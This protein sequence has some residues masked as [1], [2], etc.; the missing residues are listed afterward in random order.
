MSAS[1][2]VVNGEMPVCQVMSSHVTGQ[3][4]RESATAVAPG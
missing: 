3:M 4:L 2:V 1:L